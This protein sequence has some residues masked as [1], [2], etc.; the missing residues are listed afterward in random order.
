M[1]HEND[2]DLVLLDFM[3][4]GMSGFEV[5]KQIK[6]SER[7]RHTPVIMISAL[8]SVE[9]MIPCIESGA[10]DYLVKPVDFA[11]LKA[12]VNASLER[13]RLREREFGQFFSPEIARLVMRNPQIVR[14]GRDAD[15]SVLFCDIRRF[16]RISE[17][18]A[19]AETVRWLSDVMDQ[20]TQC[21]RG[22]GGVP[23]NYIGDELMAM[24]GAPEEVPHHAELACRAAYEILQRLPDINERWRPVVNDETTVGI[25]INSGMARVGDTGAGHKFNYGPLGGNVNLASRVQGATKYLKTPLLITGGTYD[26]LNG[27]FQARRLCQVRVVNINEPVELYEVLSEN[28]PRVDG[29][30]ERYESALEHFEK[31]ELPQAAAILGNL[32]VDDPHDGPS[33][34]ADVAR[35]RLPAASWRRIRPGVGISREVVVG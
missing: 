13:I 14:E 5:L 18:L 28:D 12:R 32:L 17:R 3:M 7:L 31:Q 22:H 8:D 23:V 25:G 24:W 19:P 26:K 27:Q 34:V 6:S 10:D 2:Y 9:D 1:L 15:V 20:F 21:V 29:L 35:R 30:K 33:A 16:S 11:L 4:P